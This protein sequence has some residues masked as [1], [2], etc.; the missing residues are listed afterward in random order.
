[1]RCLAIFYLEVK[2]PKYLSPIKSIKKFCLDC[3]DGS[4]KER[5]LCIDTD[6]PLYPYRL[7]HN[8]NIS[9]KSGRNFLKNLKLGKKP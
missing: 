2:M 7:G 5:K 1:M 3:V 4:I 6:C 9:R 8:P